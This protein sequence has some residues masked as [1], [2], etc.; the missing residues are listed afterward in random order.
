MS[1]PTTN[2]LVKLRQA[3]HW[4]QEEVARRAGLSRPEISAIETGRLVPS[5]AA[6]LQLARAFECAVEE[7][8]ALAALERSGTRWA[9]PPRERGRFWQAKVLDT[10]VRYPAEVTPIGLMPHDGLARGDSV[11]LTEAV[12]PSATLVVSGCDP[13][14]GLLASELTRMTGFR[15]LPLGR[16][17]RRG[18]ELL[19]S[20]LIH[21]AGVHL[22]DSDGKPDNDRV[23]SSLGG[24]H[25]LLHLARWQE[26]LAFSADLDPPGIE[27]VASAPI[28]WAIREEGSGARACLDRLLQGIAV[29]K[30]RRSQ[31][32]D[33]RTTAESIRSGNA[34]AGVCVQLAAEE[35][36]LSFLRIQTESY[37]LC[38]PESFETDP[39]FQA[40]LR[41]VRSARFR[42]LLGELPGYD[43]TDTGE[44]RTA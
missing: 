17:S 12:E 30:S 1:V 32:T 39:R 31:T 6:A 40:L 13:A 26:G 41:V 29:P 25:R 43:T 37:D 11:E 5:V 18:L 20:N 22:T 27:A 42:R 7:L 21:M 8:F 2:R 34:Q 15:L 36:G 44:K 16:G 4:T 28:R 19:Q 10:T 35:A 38:Y 24:T 9:S 33:H 14:I 23:V 3:H